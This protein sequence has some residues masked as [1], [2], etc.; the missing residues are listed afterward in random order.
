MTQPILI[1]TE[2]LLLH[3]FR[4]EDM[5]RFDSLTRD[6]HQLFGQ[7][8]TTTFLPHKKLSPIQQAETL[9][10]TAL[11][12]QHNGNGQWYFI[13]QKKGQRT[14]GMIELITPKIA[15][16]HYQLDCYPHFIEFCLSS[17][18]TGKGIMGRLLPRLLEK[19]KQ[20]GIDKIGAVAHPKNHSAVRVLYKSG[21]I[22]KASFDSIQHVYYN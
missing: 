22:K 4:A 6:I 8:S 13:T 18:H 11:I 7:H 12:N 2:D 5:K 9:L 10:Q 1:E 21:L 20:K 15:R 16:Q 19:L 17:E 14:I 3:S